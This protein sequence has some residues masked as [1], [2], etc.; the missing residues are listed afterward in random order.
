MTIA[1]P[2]ARVADGG[3]PAR[4]PLF[5]ITVAIALHSEAHERFVPLVRANA[6]A[7]LEGEPECLRFD[8]LT[9][10]SGG[11]DV[12]LYE[13]YRDRAAFE[14]HLATPHFLAFDEATRDM[15]V[16]KTIMEYRVL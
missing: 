13:I 5:A 3:D 9:P 4:A 7:S 12:L 8:V 2:H 6:A 14:R 11:D 15:V 16:K 10:L 1:T